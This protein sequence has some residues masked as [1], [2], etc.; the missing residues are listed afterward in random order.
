[1]KKI[2]IAIDGYVATGKG[3]TALGLA[4]KLWYT[5]LDTGAMY[6]A[7]AL[8]ALRHDLLTAPEEE[9]ALMLSQITLSFQ[10]NPKTN[11]NDMILNGEN[12]ENEIRQTSLSSQMKPIVVS[13]SVRSW[14]G[15]EQKRIGSWWGIVVDEY[16]R[17]LCRY[18]SER[19]DRLSRNRRSQYQSRW[20]DPDRYE[21]IDHRRANRNDISTCFSN[22][23]S[24]NVQLSLTE[25]PDWPRGLR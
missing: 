21:Y 18:L 4:Q 13:P 20:C 17:Y 19:W 22:N 24:I 16:W 5:Y 1:M 8:Y 23:Q 9:K 14:L 10:Y 25:L 3:T 2:I 12:I 6:R 15:E 7:V 11:H